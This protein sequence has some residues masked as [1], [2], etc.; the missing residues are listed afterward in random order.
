MEKHCP[1]CGRAD[2]E[3]GVCRSRSDGRNLYCKGC[4][5]TKVTDGRKRKR[6]WKTA[7]AERYPLLTGVS[8]LPV[9]P[10]Q[11][12]SPADRVR[13]AI[14]RGAETQKQIAQLARLGKDEVGDAI[15]ELLLWTREIRS[16]LQDDGNRHYYLNDAA[17]LPLR[18]SAGY[19]LPERK[20]DALSFSALTGL[21]PGKRKVG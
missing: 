18:A 5:R 13:E 4:I 1:I 8:S 11:T 16:A 3:F 12:L 17:V 14:K 7:R 20:P 21:M 2:V 10:A 15:A 9:V 19:I 6:E